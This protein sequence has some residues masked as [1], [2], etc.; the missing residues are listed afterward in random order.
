MATLGIGTTIVEC[1]RIANMIDRHGEQF[2]LRVYTGSEIDR[3]VESAQA[4]QMFASR[5]AAKEATLKAMNCYRQQIMWT[6]IEV[7]VDR[8]TG[9][10][11]SLYGRA[12]QWAEMHGIETLHVSLAACRTHA[13]AYVVATDED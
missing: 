5:W 2:L 4:S 12:Q 10:S 9:P 6:D 8:A 13:T 1:V 11:I 7:V 3:C